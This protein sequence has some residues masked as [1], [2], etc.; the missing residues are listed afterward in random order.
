MTISA[1]LA[2]SAPT[3]SSQKRVEAVFAATNRQWDAETQPVRPHGQSALL[4]I[5]EVETP[6]VQLATKDA[7]FLD[8]IRERVAFSPIEPACQRGQHKMEGRGV[9]HGRSLNHEP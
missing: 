8:K 1:T 9:D 6:S 2:S 7:L 4:V 3:K 5:G